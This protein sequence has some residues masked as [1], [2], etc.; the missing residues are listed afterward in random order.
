MRRT[1]I[2]CTLGPASS[3]RG[4]V[5]AMVRAGMDVARINFSHGTRPEHAR[6]VELVREAAKAE[7]KAV[8]VLQDIQG[9]KVRVGNLPAPLA[10]TPG[11]RVRLAPQSR[12]Q[13]A[14]P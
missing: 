6:Q 1:K 9:P 5:R 7:G 13:D 3:E 11:E 10:L 4:V 8:S 12:A 2:V 14:I